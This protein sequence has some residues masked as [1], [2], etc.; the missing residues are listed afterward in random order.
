MNSLLCLLMFFNPKQIEW[1]FAETLFE[2]DDG[3]DDIAANARTIRIWV[4]EVFEWAVCLLPHK[5]RPD[6]IAL[7][8]VDQ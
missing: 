2:Q 1:F 4:Q 8:F 6:S 5:L 7:F 3:K